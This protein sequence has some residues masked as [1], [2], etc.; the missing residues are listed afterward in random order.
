MTVGRRT[1]PTMTTY[2]DEPIYNPASWT[3]NRADAGWALLG[4]VWSCACAGAATTFALSGE[5][6]IATTLWVISG[7]LGLAALIALTAIGCR[8]AFGQVRYAPAMQP[9]QPGGDGAPGVRIVEDAPR[10]RRSDVQV[11]VLIGFGIVLAATLVVA[12]ITMAR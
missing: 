7:I 6:E 1:L 2:S 10:R 9:T 8:L 11:M 4:A 5:D 12:V 3:A